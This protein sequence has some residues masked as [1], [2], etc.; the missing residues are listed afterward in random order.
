MM[1][2][3]ITRFFA[4]ALILGGAIGG[5]LSAMAF[6][7]TVGQGL[8]ASA[9]LALGG[10]LYVSALVMGVG[11][12][13]RRQY[14]IVGAPILFAL[15]VPILSG[16][17]FSYSWFTGAAATYLTGTNTQRWAFEVGAS[18]T[19]SFASAGTEWAYG[20]N[21]FALVAAACLAAVRPNNSSKPTPLR[22]AA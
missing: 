11:L 20:I 4:S 7:Q 21:I 16:P 18:D 9:A 12:W 17:G 19:L 13:K 10:L 22:G 15:Q 5:L 14:G 6:P 1:Y 3:W 2:L 8:A